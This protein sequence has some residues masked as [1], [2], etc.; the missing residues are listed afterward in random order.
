MYSEE[1]LKS[2]YLASF[3]VRNHNLQIS[4]ILSDISRKINHRTYY[5]HPIWGAILYHGESKQ[6]NC[7]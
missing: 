2:P 3:I 4:E 1:M 7:R 6:V 5:A